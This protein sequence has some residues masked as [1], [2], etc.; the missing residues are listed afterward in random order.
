MADPLRSFAEDERHST[1]IDHELRETASGIAVEVVRISGSAERESFL[2]A[3]HAAHY[4][5][6]LQA[7][8]AAADAVDHADRV[9]ILVRVMLNRNRMAAARQ[10][11]MRP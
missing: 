6:L 9:I 11:V 8:T 10:I 3:A 2:E 5:R 1:G 4:K 7:G